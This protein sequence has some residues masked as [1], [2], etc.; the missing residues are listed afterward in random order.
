MLADKE[1]YRTNKRGL[2]SINNENGFS[3]KLDGYNIPLE[4]LRSININM[5]A[6]HSNELVLKYHLSDVEL[7]GIKIDVA[8]ILNESD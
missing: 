3:V 7:E 5:E 6:P 4:R 2:L 1:K 8:K